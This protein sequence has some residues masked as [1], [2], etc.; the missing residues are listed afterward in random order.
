[1]PGRIKVMIEKIIMERAKGNTVLINTTKTKLLLKGINPDKFGAES[2]D[3]PAV[4]A[5]LQ[6]LAQELNVQ[7]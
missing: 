5:K 1:M 4:I 2:P 6:T 3:D 7:L